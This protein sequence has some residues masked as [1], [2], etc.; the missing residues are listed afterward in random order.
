METTDK[1][2]AKKTASQNSVRWHGQNDGQINPQMKTAKTTPFIELS[3][4]QQQ[5]TLQEKQ[6]RDPFPSRYICKDSVS[7]ILFL[8]LHSLHQP[9]TFSLPPSFRLKRCIEL[10]LRHSVVDRGRERK[11]M[12]NTA[13]ASGFLQDKKPHWIRKRWF[14]GCIIQARPMG[15]DESALGTRR[16]GKSK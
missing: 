9:L 10:A 4:S 13:A 7:R 3:Q 2:T 1:K 11:E 6:Q 12:V 16:G 15:C 14:P 5:A 8:L